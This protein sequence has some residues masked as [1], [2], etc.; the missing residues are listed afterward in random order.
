MSGSSMN[1]TPTPVSDRGLVYVTSGYRTRPIFAIRGGA[2]GDIS[3]ADGESSNAYVAWS[4]S[5]D[6]PYIAT[7]LVYRGH[8]YVVSANGV[9]TVF[10]AT[11]G[12]RASSG[13]SAIPAAPTARHPSP[14]TVVST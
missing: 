7:P 14:R 12:E 2:T 10:D 6:G 9:L 8:L 5:R 3:L 11:T 13:A 4:S 1:T